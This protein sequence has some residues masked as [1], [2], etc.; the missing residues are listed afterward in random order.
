MGSLSK[1]QR[2]RYDLRGYSLSSLL[3]I[4]LI[5][6][7]QAQAATVLPAQSAPGRIDPN[8]IR[9]QIERDQQQKAIEERANRLLVPALRGEAPADQ[10]LPDQEQ[11]ISLSGITFNTSVYI[12]RSTLEDIAH[13]YVGREVTF[14]DLNAL[15]RQVNA[16]YEQQ[17]Q[18]T[19]RAMIPPQSLDNGVLKVVLVEAKVDAVQ[20]QG[21]PGQV[22]PSF[23]EARL[24]VSVGQTLDSRALMTAVQR[25]NATTLGPQVSASLAPGQHFG[26]TQVDLE[27]FEPDPLQWTLFANNYG[28]E[29]TGR[30]QYGGTLTWFSPT[31]VADALSAIVVATSGSQYGSLRYSRPVNTYNG[32][33]YV[34]AGANTLKIKKGPF[35]ALNI[36]GDSQTY[37]LGYDQ[38]MW[39]DEHWSLLGGVGYDHQTS[40]TTIEGLDLSDTSV[41]EFTLKG[42]VEYRAAP[43]YG[44]YEQR[45][46]QAGTENSVS[47]ESGSFQLLNGDAYLSRDFG[48][49]FQAVARFGWQY[50]ARASALPST[51]LYQFGGISSVR[52]YEPGVIASPEGMTLNLEWYWNYS[53]RWQ[54]FVFFDY[55]RAMAPGA[56]DVDLQSVGAGVNFKFGKHL[57]I[58]LVAANTLKDVVADQDSSEVL[59]QIILR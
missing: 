45:V 33:V 3:T 52:G 35:A 43:W 39:V 31:G 36:E 24:P 10:V 2:P 27:A 32:V 28:T 16:L 53:E 34:E 23:Y 15:L 55:G 49:Q 30:E 8:L 9:E 48:S 11:R 56:S 17:G 25:F 47:G 38:P 58:S 22:K 13:N 12:E 40:N 59:A 7:V 29:G 14:G 19:A 51:L 4:S 20:W 50:S 46:R 6:A 42:Q 57:S 18:L 54:P 26:T 1:W 21:K 5:G 41:N 37:G 44:R